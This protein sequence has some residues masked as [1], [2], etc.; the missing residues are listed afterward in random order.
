[1]ATRAEVE[2]FHAEVDD[3]QAVMIAALVAFWA[4]NVSPDSPADSVDDLQAFTL[5]LATDFGQ[6]AAAT[7][8]DFYE[9]IRPTGAPSF[10]PI[11]VVRDEPILTGSLKWATSPLVTED[12]EQTLDRLAAELQ[13]SALQS[14]LETLGEASEADPLRD[15]KFARFPQNSN[16]CAYCVLRAGRGAVY[17]SEET[18]TRG[19]HLK[20]GC[21]VAIVF[22]DEPLPYQRAKYEAQYLDGASAA[23]DAI[24]A[25][26]ADK[27]LSS[28]ERRAAEFK[29]LLA[30][31]RRANGLR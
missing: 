23:E 27:S 17:W 25:I 14:A 10:S 28:A 22:P 7:A 30:G 24:K 6:A 1:M 19:D 31:M 13:K 11:P 26:R 2:D 18:A 3:Q 8:V 5:E 12:F 29:A 16:P 9:S 21:R 15:V 20:C 4:A